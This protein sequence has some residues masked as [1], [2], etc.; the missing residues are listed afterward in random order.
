[1]TIRRQ[2][3]LTV[4]GIVAACGLAG[5]ASWRAV[6]VLRAERARATG[7]GAEKLALAGEL[8]A[9]ANILRTG[10]RGLLLNAVQGDLEGA[11]ATRKEYVR[12]RGEAAALT[13]KLR[14]LLEAEVELEGM[15]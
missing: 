13:A 9:A 11:A 4:G 10:Q 6:D 5:V 3:L 12:R 7:K 15:R 8:K 14:P 1:M 2:L